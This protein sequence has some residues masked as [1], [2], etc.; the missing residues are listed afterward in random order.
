MKFI[1]IEGCIGSGK[2]TLAARLAETLRGSALL[3][4]TARHPFIHDFYERP[5]AF[6]LETEAAFVLI[7]YHQLLRH[8]LRAGCNSLVVT[9]F[10]LERDWVFAQVTLRAQR[11]RILFQTLYDDLSER[12]AQENL[13]VYLAA[14]LDFLRARIAQRGRDYESNIS[15]SYL[16]AVKE[17]LD[18]Y[19]LGSYAGRKMVFDARDLDQSVNANYVTMV[20][21][22]IR[23]AGILN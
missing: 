5:D 12:I 15:D 23:E 1:R 16:L 20:A 6:A 10:S 18:N 7:H 19:F 3:E 21:D 4:E 13:L 11:D 22:K 8:S 9:D 17:A 14:P 2:T